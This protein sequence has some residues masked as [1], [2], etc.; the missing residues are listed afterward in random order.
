[1]VTIKDVARRA[2]VST[3][4]VSRCMNRKEI[5]SNKTQRRVSKAIQDLN[6]QPSPIARALHARKSSVIGLVVPVVDY[7][8]FSRLTDSV[9]RAC[10][11]YG[12]KLMLCQSAYDAAR[13]LEMVALLK[14][15]KV[16]GILLCSTLGDVSLYTGND[17]PIVS[18]D[19][20][21]EG[22]PSVTADNYGG[23]AMAAAALYDAGCRHPLLLTTEVPEYMA[24]YQRQRGFKDKC[25]DSGMT[26][27]EFI[28]NEVDFPPEE[29]VRIKSLFSRNPAIDGVF[30]VGD[31]TAAGFIHLMLQDQDLLKKHLPLVG[32]DGLDIS[33]LFEFSTIAQPINEMGEH[34]VEML[35]HRINGMTVPEQSK[36]AVT[37]IERKSTQCRK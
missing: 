30:A 5:V 2:G 34:A 28:M 3:A 1:M 19:R 8:F 12:Y 33:K 36:L 21:I 9:E 32:F 14:A 29:T 27:Q 23:G 6:Y 26:Y 10:S 16:D 22:V 25:D 18:I 37:Y 11:R 24:M 20:E 31:M 35:V 15:N 4:T 13:E 17:F 7:A